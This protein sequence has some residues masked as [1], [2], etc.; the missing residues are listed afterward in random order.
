MVE[1]GRAPARDDLDL[2]GVLAL[3][4]RTPGARGAVVLTGQADAALAAGRTTRC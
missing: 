3:T 1:E 2:G 4:R